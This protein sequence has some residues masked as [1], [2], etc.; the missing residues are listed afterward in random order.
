MAHA[1][2]GQGHL[3]R[4]RRLSLPLPRRIE[5][6]IGEHGSVVDALERRDVDAAEQALRGHLQGVLA[7]LDTIQADRPELFTGPDAEP[8]T[9]MRRQEHPGRRG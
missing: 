9:P 4:T 7:D 8:E 5:T 6:L 3:D 1:R 2:H